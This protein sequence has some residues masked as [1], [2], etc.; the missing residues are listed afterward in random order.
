MM[1]SQGSEP[2]AQVLI[3]ITAI[4]MIISG[5]L[6]NPIYKYKGICSFTMASALALLGSSCSIKISGSPAFLCTDSIG[7]RTA[8]AR[9][10]VNAATIERKARSILVGSKCLLCLLIISVA[11][12]K[13]CYIHL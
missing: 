11:C 5:K 13:L 6:T 4:R 7:F 1:K 9:L 3:F 2:K 8:T 10:R 12:A